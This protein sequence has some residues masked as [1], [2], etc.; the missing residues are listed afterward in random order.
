MLA[1]HEKC[2]FHDNIDTITEQQIVLLTTLLKMDGAC[3]HFE[4]NSFCFKGI[5]DGTDVCHAHWRNSNP[6][7]EEM[8]EVLLKTLKIHKPLSL[9]SECNSLMLCGIGNKCFRCD[10]KEFLSEQVK[11]NT[12]IEKWVYNSKTHFFHKD[13]Y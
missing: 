8:V 13:L 5:L 6:T 1:N 4:D 2:F 11:L 10:N 9:C 3:G 12:K 7:H